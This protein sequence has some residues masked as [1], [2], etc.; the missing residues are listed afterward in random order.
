MVNRRSGFLMAMAI[1]LAAA[2]P[3]CEY[4]DKGPSPVT[5]PSPGAAFLTI[6]VTPDPL[7]VLWVCPSSDAY[8]YGSLD[9]TVT[10][11]ETAGVGGRLDSVDFVARESLLGVELTTL[12][13]SAD[14]IKAKAGT[15]RIEAMGK[16]AVRPIIEGY[17]VKNNIPRPKLNIDISV[18]GTDDKGNVVKQNKRVP[19]S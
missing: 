10:V 3:G 9:S 19:V 1:L 12:H 6:D 13:L 11:S 7:R 18:Q 15:N 16:L 4:F 2:L 17:P 5:R 8:C 14:D